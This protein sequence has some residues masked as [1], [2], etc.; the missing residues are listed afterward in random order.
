[1]ENE[2]RYDTS[3]ANRK[4]TRRI[5]S[6][7]LLVGGLTYGTGGNGISAAVNCSA[8]GLPAIV[9]ENCK[10]GNDRADW[11]LPFFSNAALKIPSISG[12]TTQF[13]VKPGATLQFKVGVKTLATPSYS[14]RVDVYRVGHYSG[15]GARLVASLGPT[16]S[17]Q[18][19]DAGCAFR[20]LAAPEAPARVYDCTSWQLSP[21]SW[22]IPSTAVSGFYLAKVIRTDG[23]VVGSDLVETT[24][25]GPGKVPVANHIPFVIR[26]SDAP[27]SKVAYQMS[28]S[29]WQAYNNF[30]VGDSTLYSTG[31]VAVSYERPFLNRFNNSENGPIQGPLHSWADID[32]PMIGY[33]ESNGF[34]VSYVS[35]NDVDRFPGLLAS[36]KVFL[37]VGHD[38]YWSGPQRNAVEAAAGRAVNPSN[39]MFLGGNV[40][41]WKTRWVE[42]NRTLISYKKS[43]AVDPLKEGPNWTGLWKDTAAQ[44]ALARPEYQLVGTSTAGAFVPGPTGSGSANLS[45]TSAQAVHRVWRNTGCQTN[46][47]CSLGENNL[48][49]EWDARSDRLYGSPITSQP[50]GVVS[51]LS[52]D[53]NGSYVSYGLHPGKDIGTNATNVPFDSTLYKRTNGAIVFSAGTIRWAYGLNPTRASGSSGVVSAALQQFM[54][55]LLADM[56]A[57]PASI[58]TGVVATK[59][60]DVVAPTST[61]TYMSNALVS[62]SASDVGGIVAG[63]EISF[64]SGVTWRMA[65]LSGSGPTR[66]WSLESV[67]PNG[68]IVRSRAV[69]DSGNIQLTP[70]IGAAAV[71]QGGGWASTLA[72]TGNTTVQADHVGTQKVVA[73]GVGGVGWTHIVPVKINGDEISDL[74][75]YNASSGAWVSTTGTAAGT[76]V[77]ADFNLNNPDGAGWTHIVPV[78]NNSDKI[79]DFYFYRASSGAWISTTGTASGTQVA[80]QNLTTSQIAAENGLPLANRP[81]GAGWSR[82]V[83]VQ[84]NSDLLTD[85]YFVN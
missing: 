47:N 31:N 3:M 30:N 75:F 32:L 9:A 48:G 2:R 44:P 43:A 66:S 69:D 78:N 81:R 29:S 62:G 33:L 84:V 60:T 35:S 12:F 28:D 53:I 14:Y 55:N 17:S 4:L 64:D 82:I 67:G 57:Q 18:N 85:L 49:F 70:T 36:T 34:D 72:L 42:N 1:M 19:V 73:S 46:P 76:L 16:T 71:P 58:A 68:R 8:T 5:F 6:V 21:L 41:Y 38:E 23:V 15:K 56:D 26:S 11:D 45:L 80:L 7:V 59:S 50:A 25:A 54:I 10:V 83:P 63:V 74:Y 77:T 79:T 61:I 65:D 52:A 27:S 40:V 39:L 37:S 51:V 20:N 22:A 24:V 13:S